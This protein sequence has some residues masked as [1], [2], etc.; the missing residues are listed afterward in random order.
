M[1]WFHIKKLVVYTIDK[2]ESIL[3]VD[4]F[5]NLDDEI[6]AKIESSYGLSNWGL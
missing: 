3:G 1:T 5:H 6:E 4:F 2:V